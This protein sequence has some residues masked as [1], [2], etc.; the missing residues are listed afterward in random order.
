M[1]NSPILC[2]ISTSSHLFKCFALADSIKE[3]GG[4]LLVLLVDA[5]SYTKAAPSN[6]SFL[7]L[8]DLKDPI[9]MKIKSK[10]ATKMDE[11]RWSLKPVLLKHLL[12]SHYKAIYID[13]EI[14]FFNDYRFLWDL[15]DSHPIL[16]TPHH[17]PRDP[18]QQQNWFEANFRV[19][20]YNA[21]FLAANHE[22][23]ETLDWWAA[24]CLYRCEKSSWRG[25]FD[26]QKYLDLVP[27]IE[28]KTKVLEHLGC[29]VA[30]WN[31]V[32]CKRTFENGQHYI[33]GEFPLI[34]YHFNP[35]SLQ[36]LNE[37]DPVLTNYVKAL[38]KYQ[39]N[40][41]VSRQSNILAGLKLKV[42]KILNKFNRV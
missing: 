32:L 42:W 30:E 18:L 39:A 17:Y 19:G 38:Q 25:L 4:E 1:A 2:T 7:Y 36:N 26:D 11:L 16:L 21:G 27:I 37:G 33:N 40:F 5:S 15:F 28:P 41:K 22:A 8:Q 31:A 23:K 6:V 10:Y 20:L 12:L 34:F 13:N 9:A 3:I 14:L 29:N 35:H 24:S